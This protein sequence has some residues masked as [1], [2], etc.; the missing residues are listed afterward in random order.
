MVN[1]LAANVLDFQQQTLNFQKEMKDF[2]QKTEVS[3]RELTTS[4]EK[5]T[6]QGKLPSQTEPNPRQNANAVMLQSRKV[7]RYGAT[8]ENLLRNIRYSALEQTQIDV[9]ML[10]GQME[11]KVLLASSID[12]S[13][14]PSGAHASG[15]GDLNMPYF[16]HLAVKCD[17]N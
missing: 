16:L 6:S 10:K 4:I 1:K 5:L 17:K 12:G 9:Q 11:T 7:W 15:L 2:Q 13:L 3:I 8:D 14:S